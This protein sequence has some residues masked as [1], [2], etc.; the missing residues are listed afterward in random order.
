MFRWLLSLAAALLCFGASSA[1][2]E[3]PSVPDEVGLGFFVKEPG[4][5]G[6]R[7]EKWRSEESL[8]RVL[9]KLRRGPAG[10]E[11]RFLPGRYVIEWRI[12]VRDIEDLLIAGGPGVEWVFADGP[13]SL[14]VLEQ[15]IRPG[16]KT[17]RVRHPER[18]RPKRNYQ[19]YRANGTDDRL[20]EFAVREI[21]GDEVHLTRP[22]T[23]MPHVSGIASGSDVIKEVNF[24]R[25]LRCPGLT[26][27][28]I[29]FDGRQRGG[30]RTH[31]TYCGIYA[32][33]DYLPHRRPVTSG[34]TVRGCSFRNLK[35]RG[36]VFY[37]I[38]KALVEGNRFENIRAQAIEID[39]FS[40]GVIRRN[41]VVGAEVGVMVN[42]AFESVVE[43]NVITHCKHA[44]RLYE[45]YAEEWVNTG[46]TVRDNV[47]GPGCRAGVMF[48]SAGLV[49]NVV[50]GNTFRGFSPKTRVVNGEG[51][52]IRFD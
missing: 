48:Y 16:D 3:R 14:T 28:G 52:R 26:V 1:A 50:E 46:N 17:I 41:V 47:L 43:A 13:D 22:A 51:N 42:D 30:L 20:L 21:V 2:Q 8:N 39:H 35:G 40:S 33:G 5:E 32:S 9:R 10:A 29:A 12:L 36:V 44:V 45:L 19:V 25:V 34:L 18:L 31:T 6:S 38:E 24:L 49:D 4:A 15:E 23:F 7:F 27:E 11:I 37:G